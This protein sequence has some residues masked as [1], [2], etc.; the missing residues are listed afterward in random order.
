MFVFLN[1]N[2]GLRTYSG[3][4]FFNIRNFTMA[5]DQFCLR[6]NNFQLNIASAL[7]SLKTDEDLVDVTLSCE[8]QNVKAHKVVLSACS[9]YFRGVFKENPCQHPIVIL[10]NV[11]YDDVCALLSFMYQ[12]EVYIT[13]DRLSSFLHTAELLQVRG[14]AGATNP[15]KDSPK[16]CKA[17]KP[18]LTPAG[19]LRHDTSPLSSPP[20]VSLPLQTCSKTA[21]LHP[22]SKSPLM[23]LKEPH[24]SS[25]SLVQ[26]KPTALNSSTTLHQ[27]CS[28]VTQP[29]SYQHSTSI[30]YRNSATLDQ[31]ASYQLSSGSQ[32]S[33]QSAFPQHQTLTVES[34]QQELD[35]PNRQSSSPQPPSAKRRKA[36][37]RRVSVGGHVSTEESVEPPDAEK[38]KTKSSEEQIGCEVVSLGAAPVKQ[39]PEDEAVFEVDATVEEESNPITFSNADDEVVQ[40]ESPASDVTRRLDYFGNVETIVSEEPVPDVK[41]EAMVE[42]GPSL[43]P[44]SML[45]RS[46]SAAKHSAVVGDT[47]PSRLADVAAM[48]R[49]GDE[50]DGDLG[51][52]KVAGGMIPH[53]PQCG[54]CPHC[55]QKYSNQSALKYHVRLM[56][57]DMTNTLCCHLCPRSFAMRDVYKT[58]MWEKHKQRC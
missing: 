17:K 52:T 40:M 23:T 57:S 25:F 3:I 20:A 44:H 49:T 54:T 6:W 48:T 24:S 16:Q 29:S 7:D 32:Q 1:Q 38:V 31:S 46:L 12:G 21:P 9:P 5:A 45:L 39:E 2:V 33:Q 14:L 15:F 55:G 35:Q 36:F 41:E 22:I 8:G 4:V 30:Q 34:S 28:T 19:Q 51:P 56:H 11:S 47:S 58:H 18:L 50:A 37:P 42:G 10:K 43:T 53:V 13:Q 27:H 26:T